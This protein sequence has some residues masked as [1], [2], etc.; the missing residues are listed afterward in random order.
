M[1]EAGSVAEGDQGKTINQ[2][3]ASLLAAYVERLMDGTCG[4]MATYLDLDDGLLRF[5]PAEP[6]QVASVVGLHP[7]ALL[8]HAGGHD[9]TPLE[10]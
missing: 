5:V 6:Y 2:M 4:W 3:M 7:N 1:I 9:R 10:G 8:R